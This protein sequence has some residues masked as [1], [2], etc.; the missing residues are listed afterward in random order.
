MIKKQMMVESVTR[1]EQLSLSASHSEVVVEAES[2]GIT[3]ASVRFVLD[4]D[5]QPKVGDMISVTIEL[6]EPS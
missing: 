5:Q 3:H 6:G 2:N 4:A 1:H